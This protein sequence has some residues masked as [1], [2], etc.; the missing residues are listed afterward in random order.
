ML[1]HDVPLAFR[2]TELKANL[3]LLARAVELFEPRLSAR[4]LRTLTT[5]RRKLSRQADGLL[6]LRQVMEESYPKGACAVSRS[7]R[8][9]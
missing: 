2:P 3:A 1:T 6:V 7:H 4:V 9:R 5:V 8:L